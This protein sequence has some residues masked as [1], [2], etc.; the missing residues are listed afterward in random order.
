MD[1][2]TTR[3]AAR[4]PAGPKSIAWWKEAHRLQLALCDDLEAI[5]DSLPASIVNQD[6]LL[7]AK[8]LGRLIR[9]V[10]AYEEETLFPALRHVFPASGDFTTAVDRLTFEHLADEC[11][12]EDILSRSR[13][14]R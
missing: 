2:K 12:A 3:H 8:D 10:H 11:Y 9:D 14:R 7:A 1:P 6:C 5:A 13:Q 4:A